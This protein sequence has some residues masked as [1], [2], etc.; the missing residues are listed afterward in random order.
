MRRET[1]GLLSS[2]VTLWGVPGDPRH[3]NARGWE[4]VGGGVFAAQVG[5]SC[6]A[7][8]ELSQQPLL[9]LPTSCAADPQ[10][11]PV[12]FSM[13]SDSWAAPGS[14]LGAEYAWMN[15]EGRRLGFEGCSELQ[16]TPGI[17]VTPEQHATSTPTGLSVDV[18]VPQQGTLQAGGRA[19]ADVRDTTVTLP[20]GVQL[21]PS[22]ANGLESCTE[23]QIGFL[24]VN[25]STHT[26]EFNTTE[27][28]CPNRSKI[29]T[30]K[31]KTPLLSDELEGAAYLAA[32]NANPFGSLLAVYLVAQDPVSGTL[33]KLAGDTVLDPSAGQL[34]TT[35]DGLPQLPFEDLELNLFGGNRAPLATPADCG[36]YTTAAS[37]TP[38]RGGEAAEDHVT[39]T[40]AGGPGG[41][42]CPGSS[43]PFGPSFSS[44]MIDAGGGAFSTLSTTI[45]REDGQQDIQS[46]TLHM[47]PG[48]SG[49]LP[50]SSCAG[51]R[52]PTPARAD[53]KA[54]SAKRASAWAWAPNRSRSGAQGV[55]HRSV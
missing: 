36:S 47:P 26:D 49:L 21:N 38:W 32:Q 4:C 53:L 52:R 37:F 19:E 25:Q 5:R 7:S 46:V 2:Q 1:A 55:H 44:G 17:S 35:F 6:P 14:F 45:G 43:L 50:A 48:L 15:E 42:A 41:G 18:S 33:V 51:N 11:E 54:R 28:T 9:T 23:A 34:V 10:A 40:I 16:F 27:P 39:F 12:L 22:A 29:G 20:Q 8:S 24:G 30:V 13:E 31:I 3:D